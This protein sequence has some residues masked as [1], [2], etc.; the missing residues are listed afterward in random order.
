MYNRSGMRQGPSGGGLTGPVPRDL[1][2][3]LGIIFATFSL[4][5]FETTAGM[6]NHL[7]LT[8]EVW[9]RGFLWQFVTFE[10]IGTG[11]APDLWFLVSLLILFMFGRDLIVRLGTREFWKFL[12]LASAFA[13]VIAVSVQLLIVA[14]GF[15]SFGTAPF[16]LMQ[17]QH[18]VLAILIA[19]FAVINAHAT[20]YLFFVLPMPARWFIPLEIVFAFLG[21]LST[22]DLAGFL[23]ITGAVGFCV[24]Y[25][26]PGGLRK[27]INDAYLRGRYQVYRARLAWMKRRRHLHIVKPADEDKKDPWIH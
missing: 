20:I 24:A 22:R 27:A 19:A 3:L 18:I 1:W 23:G 17:G 12:I 25:L 26:G 2:V 9:Q 8:P 16:V 6:I 10:F 21:F 15:T 7:R 4:Q 5:F 13:A 14:F 11:R